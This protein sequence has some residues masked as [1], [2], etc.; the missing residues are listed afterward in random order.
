M[1][2]LYGTAPSVLLDIP[3]SLSHGMLA[4]LLQS[5]VDGTDDVCR[6]ILR[7]SMRLGHTMELCRCRRQQVT[8]EGLFG[9]GVGEGG[10]EE[11]RLRRR[12]HEEVL[13][14]KHMTVCFSMRMINVV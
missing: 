10:E 11:V 4:P 3:H 14:F 7:S 5:R 1:I 12:I 6:P 13:P 2:R 9:A 8:N